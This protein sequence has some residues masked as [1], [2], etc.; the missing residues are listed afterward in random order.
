MRRVYFVTEGVTDQIVL[1]ALV[2]K[3]L[4]G[5]EFIPRHIQ[6]PTSALVEGSQ[7]QLSQ[8]WKG[9]LAWLK[10]ERPAGPAGRDHALN[11]AH[12]LIV[13]VDADVAADED[14]ASPPFAGTCPPA[15]P[16]CDWVRARLAAALGSTPPNLVWCVPAQSTEAWVLAAL[17]PAVA[18]QH[19]PRVRARAGAPVDGD[20]AAPDPVEGQA[21]AQGDGS[22][23]GTGGKIRRRL[24]RG[25]RGGIAALPRGSPL[26]ARGTPGAHFSTHRNLTRPPGV[27]TIAGT[28]RASAERFSPCPAAS[29]SALLFWPPP[30]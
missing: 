27:G 16:Q 22:L 26:R 24:G 5:S 10:G 1:E 23:P 14:F 8:G 17:F 11:D 28:R 12:C 4:D 30:V 18:D 15:A 7:G 6:P 9:V 13:H 3:W 29:P 2:K 21:V 20:K 19:S 25:R